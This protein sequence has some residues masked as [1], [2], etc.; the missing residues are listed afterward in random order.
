MAKM[1]L[2]TNGVHGR[3]MECAGEKRVGAVMCC[4]GGTKTISLG[5]NKP[6]ANILNPT[7][8]TFQRDSGLGGILAGWTGEKGWDTLMI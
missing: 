1:M 6:L 5:F 4:E 7:L 2:R 3:N 8:R